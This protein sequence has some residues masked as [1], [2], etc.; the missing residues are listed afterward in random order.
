MRRVVIALALCLAL[1]GSWTPPAT[2]QSGATDATTTVILVRHAERAPGEGDVPLSASG[3]ERARALAQV[4]RDVDIGAIITSQMLRAK[5]TAEPLAQQKRITPD[6]LPANELDAVVEQVRGLRGRTI[7]V[8]HHSN[9]VPAIVEK[10]G[11][12]STPIR[13]DEFDRLVIVTMPAHGGP[14][15]VTLRYGASSAK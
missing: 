8:V 10:L 11:G 14:S 15:V 2:A 4:L 5:D 1:G 3:R 7:L 9:T 12:T 13:D 6:V